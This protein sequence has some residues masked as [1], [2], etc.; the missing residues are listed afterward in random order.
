MR[1]IICIFSLCFLF[2][3]CSREYINTDN[4]VY[5]IRES[6]DISYFGNI[7]QVKNDERFVF[8]SFSNKGFLISL[9]NKK[10][11][12][13]NV[14]N[15]ETIKVRVPAMLSEAE[16]LALDCCFKY[17]NYLAISSSL[18]KGLNFYIFNIKNNE[19]ELVH[20]D[21]YNKALV[22][23]IDNEFVYL[24]DN[25][26]N[27]IEYN[28]LTK[29]INK[30]PARLKNIEWSNSNNCFIG[31][32]EN[33]YITTLTKKGD[34]NFTEKTIVKGI[35]K[36]PR[37]YMHNYEYFLSKDY[38]YFAK[39]NKSNPLKYFAQYLLSFTFPTAPEYSYK[40]YRY[41][42]NNCK[43]E[44]IKDSEHIKSVLSVYSN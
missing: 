42:L 33:N 9:E 35:S 4:L 6:T 37:H 7:V 24:R 40:W 38:L 30:F 36:E 21:E 14:E 11:V 3:S 1:K 19:S 25:A 22:K 44:V 5:S 15:N 32:N 31:L 17:D 34:N 29:K 16:L 43:I 18:Q 10:L 28:Y 12:I 39:L 8:D 20:S 13:K 23:N 41:N 26:N 27:I 2:L